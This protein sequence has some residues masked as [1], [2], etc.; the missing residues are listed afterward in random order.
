MTWNPRDIHWQDPDAR[1]L[2]EMT[3]PVHALIPPADILAPSTPFIVTEHEGSA[4]AWPQT[5]RR[6]LSD[7]GMVDDL[8]WSR[9][10]WYMMRGIVAL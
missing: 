3:A 10:R 2:A 9:W 5:M 8:T 1:T 7:A 4:T 6:D